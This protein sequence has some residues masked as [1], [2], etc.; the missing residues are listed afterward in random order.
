V[1]HKLYSEV[2]RRA[3]HRCE[4]CRAP[5]AIFNLEFE[6]EHIVALARGGPD[7]LDNLALACRS[8]NLRKGVAQQAR[9]P[10]T[11][12]TARLFNP[13]ADDWGEHF[14]ISLDN[15][16]IEGLT[17]IGRATV[18][19]LGMNRPPSIRARRLWVA[20]LLIRF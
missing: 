18:R 4:Y 12:A 15:F 14:R 5:E 19:R 13:R 2:A 20:R 9:D 7:E 17:A 11:G 1:P 16:R 10:L 8:C 6:V 3:R